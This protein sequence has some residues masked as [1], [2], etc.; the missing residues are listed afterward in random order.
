MKRTYGLITRLH[1]GANRG[2]HAARHQYSQEVSRHPSPTPSYETNTSS[3]ITTS[4]STSPFPVDPLTQ[5]WQSSLFDSESNRV[6]KTHPLGSRPPPPQI[7]S[8]SYSGHSPTMQDSITLSV[9]SADYH[10]TIQGGNVG[11]VTVVSQE[12]V[13]NV[14]VAQWIPDEISTT[15][16]HIAQT[17]IVTQIEDTASNQV[18]LNYS[19]SLYKDS[20]GALAVA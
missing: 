13:G 11:N 4:T 18:Q 6:Q 12:P 16:A 20:G 5:E 7:S 9:N 10:S 1:I 14:T 19:S 17:A 3:E 15:E 8:G 2:G